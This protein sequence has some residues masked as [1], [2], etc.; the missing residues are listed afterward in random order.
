M[1]IRPKNNG[2]CTGPTRA[3]GPSFKVTYVEGGSTVEV[4]ATIDPSN[5]KT[6]VTSTQPLTRSQDKKTISYGSAGAGHIS[7]IEIGQTS[8]TFPDRGDLDDATAS[9]F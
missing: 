2:T 8:C 4:T 9:D 5:K 3:T 6:S 7:K 1:D